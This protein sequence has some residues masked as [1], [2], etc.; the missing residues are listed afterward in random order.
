[1]TDKL[2]LRIFQ[3]S[4]IEQFTSRR[5]GETKAGEKVQT[6]SS[7]NVDEFGKLLAQ[8]VENRAH[9][10]IVMVPEDIGPRANQGRAGAQEAPRAFMRYFCNMQQNKFLDFSKIL[11]VGELAVDDLMERS[12]DASQDE[13]RSLCKEVDSRLEPVLEEIF[14]H[15]LEPIIIGGGNNNSL[16][17]LRALR[18]STSTT[19]GVACVNCDPHADFRPLEGRHSGN[20]FSYAHSEGVLAA[21]CIVGLHEGYNSDSMLQALD[22][23]RFPYFSYEEFAV[24]GN[25]TFEQQVQQA[26]EYLRSEQ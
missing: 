22:K 8:A 25:T 4:D 24:R 20:P 23:V 17:I 1:M 13:L 18:A 14:K 2:H 21:Y 10:A 6:L 26:R 3:L 12:K 15:K 5:P 7:A 11:I 19:R 16:P 9:Y